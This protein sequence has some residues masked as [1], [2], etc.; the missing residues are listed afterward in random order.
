MET[1]SSYGLPPHCIAPFT[2]GLTVTQ[3]GGLLIHPDLFA[4]TDFHLFC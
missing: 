2:R 1:E 3:G 4:R